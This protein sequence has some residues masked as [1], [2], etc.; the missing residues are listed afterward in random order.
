MRHRLTICTFYGMYLI[1]YDNLTWWKSH[2]VYTFRCVVRFSTPQEVRTRC[3]FQVFN[4]MT[5]SNGIIFRITG[6]LCGEFTG[7]RWIPRTKASEAEF[8]YFLW[9]AGWING[10]VN[11]REAGD[12]RRNHAHYDGIVMMSDVWTISFRLFHCHWVNL[13][14][15]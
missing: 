5:S 14:A 10:W 8:R 12:L 6:P 15:M 11:N 13:M 4:M 1:S 2:N 3:S 7:H 9:S